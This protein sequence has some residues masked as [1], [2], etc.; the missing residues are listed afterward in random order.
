MRMGADKE[1]VSSRQSGG[2]GGRVHA[3]SALQTAGNTVHMAGGR[4]H[5]A[6][7]SL[8]RP[9]PLHSH[10]S[11]PPPTLP[12]PSPPVVRAL[13]SKH[14]RGVL[15]VG[16]H[17]DVVAL[18]RAQHVV[19]QLQGG[20]RR[21]TLQ[22]WH[23]RGGHEGGQHA[24][25]APRLWLPHAQPR[26]TCCPRLMSVSVPLSAVLGSSLQHHTQRGMRA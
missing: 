1:R 22:S 3:H 12:A 23:Q 8:R 18:G 7:P 21:G 25:L 19:H 11:H 10:R 2:G 4:R 15:G 20:K 5:M 6:S 24:Q 16:Q 14:P 9:A 26:R 17:G 13:C